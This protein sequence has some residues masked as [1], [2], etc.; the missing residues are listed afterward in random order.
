MEHTHGLYY[1][2]VRLVEAVHREQGR[3]ITWKSA[4]ESIRSYLDPVTHV[5]MQ[6]RPDAELIYQRK[7]QAFPHSILVEYDRA[8]TKAREIRAKYQTYADYLEY[9]GI[10]LPPILVI[11]QHERAAARIRACIDAVDLCLPV[12]IVLEEELERQELLTALLL[13]NRQE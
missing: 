10:S 9:T 6:V 3:I 8:T 7:G 1:C 12:I 11:T 2:M 5:P 4:S 13:S